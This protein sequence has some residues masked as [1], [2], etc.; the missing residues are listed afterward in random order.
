MTSA[1]KRKPERRRPQLGKSGF[2]SKGIKA[3]MAE[4]MS[5]CFSSPRRLPN[6]DEIESRTTKTGRVIRHNRFKKI[7]S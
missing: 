5:R 1:Q 4:E 2:T 6:L 7:I 3:V